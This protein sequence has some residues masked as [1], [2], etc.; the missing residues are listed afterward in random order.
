MTSKAAL[1]ILG[2]LATAFGFVMYIL[3]LGVIWGV[4]FP[5]IGAVLGVLCGMVA[6]GVTYKAG[7]WPRP[8][9]M[10]GA[11]WGVFIGL[12]V[13]FIC[14]GLGFKD[15]KETIERQNEVRAFLDDIDEP[16]PAG[17]SWR[18]IMKVATPVWYVFAIGPACILGNSAF[19]FSGFTPL[20]SWQITWWILGIIM[21]WGL[22]F[23]AEMATLSEDRIKR[24]DTD[25]NIVVKEA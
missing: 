12:L 5:S 7:I 6:V 16:S 19:S 24:A 14:K 21:M 11:F 18:K 4:R 20:W 2:G 9:S 10:H 25:T 23:K 3:L 1:V 17:K 13:A 8:L 15:S 22:A